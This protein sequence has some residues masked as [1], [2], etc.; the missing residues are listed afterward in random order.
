MIGIQE[1]V[2]IKLDDALLKNIAERLPFASM[3]AL[4][5]V[6]K[7]HAA[8]FL[9]HREFIDPFRQLLNHGA[10]GELEQAEALWR[11]RPNLLMHYGTI[12]HPNRIYEP[13]KPAYDIPFH[14]NPG[15]YQYLNLTYLQI[16]LANEEYEAVDKIQTILAP[17]EFARQF[18]EVFPD[19]IIKKDNF[20]LEEANILL[21]NLVEA[22]ANDE[23]INAKNFDQMNEVTKERLDAFY[24]YARPQSEHK[25]GLVFDPHLYF[26]AL[27]RYHTQAKDRFKDTR[28]KH[29]FWCIRVQEWLAS[30]LPTSYLR[31]HTQGLGN[32]TGLRRGCLLV[33]GSPYFPFRRTNHSLPGLHFFTG[34]HGG[35]VLGRG[36]QHKK[37][38]DERKRMYSFSRIMGRHEHSSKRLTEKCRLI[39][40]PNPGPM[41]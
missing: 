17:A 6:S 35:A 39:H 14:H 21:Y 9:R 41:K 16:L 5:E 15:R 11:K 25:T 23:T 24:Q 20:N 1:Q 3:I 40:E 7:H 22:I 33:D 13:N 30:C 34:Y 2:V 19:G 29:D 36:Q 18:F 12:Y 31:L 37:S 27:T 28:S 8:F 38:D 10:L 4:S 32:H 26:A